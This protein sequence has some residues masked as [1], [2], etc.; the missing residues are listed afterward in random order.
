MSFRRPLRNRKMFDTSSFCDEETTECTRVVMV[1]RTLRTIKIFYTI[2]FATCNKRTDQCRPDNQCTIRTSHIQSSYCAIFHQYGAPMSSWQRLRI[3]KCL[4]PLYC[5]TKNK[6][7]A[8]MSSWQPLQIVKF[9]TSH[10]VSC[11]QHAE[12]LGLTT[13]ALIGHLSFYL[14][15]RPFTNMLHQ[16]RLEDH[17]A[18]V[19]NFQFISLCDLLPTC[20]TCVFFDNWCAIMTFSKSS[21]CALCHQHALFVFSWQSVRNRGIF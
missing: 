1:L 11:H 16:C 7:A 18:L 19:K 21:Y 4:T 6:H 9:F 8:P 12:G 10:S 13:N 3:V 2:T 5:V 20:P 17:C 15:V 14:T